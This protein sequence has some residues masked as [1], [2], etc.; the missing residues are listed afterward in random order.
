MRSS[1][2]KSKP[3][4]RATDKPLTALLPAL[5]WLGSTAGG[6]YG[7]KGDEIDINDNFAIA[8]RSDDP[9]QAKI[10]EALAHIKADGT[11]ERI[12]QQYFAVP[13]AQMPAVADTAPTS[14]ASSGQAANSTTAE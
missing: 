8:V 1:L 11:Y 7:I 10:N 5:E 9:W 12:K 2:K 13:T 14:T 3:K 4:R 6:S